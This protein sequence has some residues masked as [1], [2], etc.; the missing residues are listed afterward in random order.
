MPEAPRS[1]G[2]RRKRSPGLGYSAASSASGP[3]R[4]LRR[5]RA[6]RPRSFNRESGRI[7]MRGLAPLL[8]IQYTDVRFYDTINR[9]YLSLDELR[10]WRNRGISFEVHDSET[11]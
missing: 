2:S 6:S 11:G 7:K 10:Q 1:P 9:K 3:R 4:Q 5:A 8:I